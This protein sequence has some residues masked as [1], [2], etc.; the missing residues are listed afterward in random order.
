MKVDWKR[1]SKM[2]KEKRE[3]MAYSIREVSKEFHVDRRTWGRA[4]A[5]RPITVRFFLALCY[6]ATV[7]P[8]AFYV[9]T[10]LKK[11]GC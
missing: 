9:T 3:A 11:K 8:M 7:D 6:W 10:P 4:E 2:V 1:F 5:G